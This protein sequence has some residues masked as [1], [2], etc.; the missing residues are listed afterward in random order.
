[1]DVANTA[2]NGTAVNGVALNG[3]GNRAAPSRMS[4]EEALHLLGLTPAAGPQEISEAHHRL[5]QKLKPE[6]G[7]THYLTM[8]IDEARD[9]LL[10][11]E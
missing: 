9:V 10:L 8:K 6:L 3:T 1:V 4:A 7:G 5:Q 11:E 2:V